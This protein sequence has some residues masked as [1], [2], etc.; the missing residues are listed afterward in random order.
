MFPGRVS[1]R[2]F[3]KPWPRWQGKNLGR[4]LPIHA[5]KSAYTCS[6][7]AKQVTFHSLFPAY[8]A[9]TASRQPE[10]GAAILPKA[11]PDRRSC[12]RH[13]AKHSQTKLRKLGHGCGP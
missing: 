11:C 4:I 10:T 8:H 3:V 9:V 7:H 2:S 12:R 13:K 6:Y 1:I 5:T